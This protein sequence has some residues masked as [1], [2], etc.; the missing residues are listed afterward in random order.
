M[1]PVRGVF[2]NAGRNIVLGDTLTSWDV[3]LLKN[4]GLTERVKLQFRAE[5]FNLANHT[6]FGTPNRNYAPVA[7]GYT[8]GVSVNTN[9]DYGRV[10][11]A[12]DPRVAQ[13]A[14][15]LYW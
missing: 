6:N 9:P 3:S 10:F 15:K 14:L 11:G 8:P 13:L 12:A 7:T 5:I 1:N 2:G 4:T